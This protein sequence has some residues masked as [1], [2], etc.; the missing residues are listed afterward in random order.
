[1]SKFFR[2]IKDIPASFSCTKCGKDA[3][4]IL[5]APSST[6]VLVVDNGVQAR[7]V[8]V[9]LEVVES[10]RDRANKNPGEK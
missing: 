6:S 10:I 3:K 8:E 9:N 7:S 4:K 2:Q 5:R 1:M